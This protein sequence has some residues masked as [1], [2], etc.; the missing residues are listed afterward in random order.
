MCFACNVREKIS[1]GLRQKRKL[2]LEIEGGIDE[3]RASSGDE[4]LLSI[5]TIRRF[6]C[7]RT[8]DAKHKSHFLRGNKFAGIYPKIAATSNTAPETDDD[9]RLSPRLRM[10]VT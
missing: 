5:L 8:F 1:D 7:Q 10:R 4:A 3:R 9:A 2:N 6:D